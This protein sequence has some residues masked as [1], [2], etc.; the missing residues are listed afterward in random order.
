MINTPPVIQV[1]VEEIIIPPGTKIPRIAPG[2]L[3]RISTRGIEKPLTIRPDRTLIDGITRLTAARELKMEM[4][5]CVIRAP[6]EATPGA[7]AAAP[8]ADAGS[9]VI[10][11]HAPGGWCSR[12][13]PG[14]ILCRRKDCVDE[15]GRRCLHYGMVIP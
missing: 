6:G 3:H 2:F 13:P 11:A 12:T 10:R 15:T 7:P 8:G 4:V 5:P 9:P 14:T 1:P